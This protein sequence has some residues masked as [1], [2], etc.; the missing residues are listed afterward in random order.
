MSA[1]SLND[2]LRAYRN[3]LRGELNALA[4]RNLVRLNGIGDLTIDPLVIGVPLA[5]GWHCLMP[6]SVF[7]DLVDHERRFG[8]IS[9]IADEDRVLSGIDLLHDNSW[10]FCRDCLLPFVTMLNGHPGC[11]DWVNRIEDGAE[12]C[13]CCWLAEH[14]AG[15]R[16]KMIEHALRCDVGD[17]S[18]LVRVE[19]RR[20]RDRDGIIERLQRSYWRSPGLRELLRLHR[21]S[22]AESAGVILRMLEALIVEVKAKEGERNSRAE[23]ARRAIWRDERVSA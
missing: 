21:V 15:D 22:M 11:G 16:R 17:D 4:N 18:R 7:N 20:G 13:E 19:L 14:Y 23:A 6:R 3:D 2:S 1:I 9:R 8:R 10:P 12:L 5:D